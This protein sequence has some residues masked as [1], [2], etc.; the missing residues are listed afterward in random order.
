MFLRFS[1]F[2]AVVK[3]LGD[4]PVGTTL[5]GTSSDSAKEALPGYRKSTPV[6]FMGLFPSDPADF[7]SLR[8]ALQK[9]KLTDASLTFEVDKSAALGTGF[10]VGFSGLLHADVVQQRLEDDFALDLTASSPSVSYY[11]SRGNNEPWSFVANPADIVDGSKIREPIA[12]VDILCREEDL[13]AMIQLAES[14]RGELHEQGYVGLDRV[15]LSY[16]LPLSELVSD[17]YDALKQRSSGYATMDFRLGEHR[18]NN[19]ARMDFLVAGEK[20]DGLTMVVD[21]PNAFKR[22]Q[23]I[24]KKLKEHIP[25]HNFKVSIQ[26][27][28]GSKVVASE[29]IAPYRFVRSSVLSRCS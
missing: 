18:E 5:V 3:E 4:A 1:H 15:R 20:L 9:L 25:R 16:T 10:R 14:R 27:V 17:F 2:Y 12:H 19:L 7:T 22:A 21:R 6:V 26:A 29:H 13:G 24:V 28:M 8:S 23:S 11:V